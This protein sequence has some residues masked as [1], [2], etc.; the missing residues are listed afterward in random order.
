VKVVGQVAW[1][2]T[3]PGTRGGTGMGMRFLDLAAADREAIER[4]LAQALVAQIGNTE[5]RA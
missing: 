5:E 4:H 2:N 3:D 1:R